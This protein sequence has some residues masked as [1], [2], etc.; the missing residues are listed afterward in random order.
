MSLRSNVA[1]SCQQDL[2]FPV[3]LRQVIYSCHQDL[4]ATLIPN[5]KP[6]KAK[7]KP[8]SQRRQKKERPFKLSFRLGSGGLGRVIS[9]LIVPSTVPVQKILRFQVQWRWDRKTTLTH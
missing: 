2:M 7:Q 8:F 5:P 6:R 4:M 3:R 9:L 1:Y